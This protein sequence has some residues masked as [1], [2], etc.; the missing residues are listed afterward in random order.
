MS[1]APRLQ[2]SCLGWSFWSRLNRLAP[3]GRWAWRWAGL[4]FPHLRRRH[5]GLREYSQTVLGYKV[6]RPVGRVIRDDADG[7][8][9][10]TWARR[11]PS[12]L[13]GFRQT[14]CGGQWG[15]DHGP[16]TG[17][18]LPGCRDGSFCLAAAGDKTAGDRVFSPTYRIK[19]P[20]Y[21]GSMLTGI[22]DPATLFIISRA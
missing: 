9:R 5:D 18:C 21:W 7:V 19:P 2:C 3:L 12:C 4:R 11:S 14:L 16:C 22:P 15:R 1:M 8:T 13:E 20:R 10:P 6:G 17:K